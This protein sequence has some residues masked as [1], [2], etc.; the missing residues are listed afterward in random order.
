[1]HN[2]ATQAGAPAPVMDLRNVKKLGEAPPETAPVERPLTPRELPLRVTYVAPDGKRHEDTVTSR[3][4]DAT[5]R[6]EKVRIMAAITGRAGGVW[7]ALPITEQ[8]YVIALA[9]VSVQLRNIPDWLNKWAPQD[10]A[11]L[12]QL[13]EACEGHAS[14]Y[15]RRD[16]G[17]SA[18]DA[19]GARVSV[20]PVDVPGA[21]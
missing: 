9:T 20:A 5:D 17:A 3:V 4:M 21:A 8:A 12:M 19:A 2:P 13:F 18:A 15:F 11:L 1:M 7:G 16:A 14:R 10:D 6:A